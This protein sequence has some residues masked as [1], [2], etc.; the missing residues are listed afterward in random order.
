M[1][2]YSIAREFCDKSER[3]LGESNVASDAQAQRNT[4]VAMDDA[5]KVQQREPKAP[6]KYLVPDYEEHPQPSEISPIYEDIDKFYSSKQ[7]TEQSGWKRGK[8]D[9]GK[10]AEKMDRHS[11]DHKKKLKLRQTSDDSRTMLINSKHNKSQDEQKRIFDG[12]CSKVSE[13]DQNN[14]EEDIYETMI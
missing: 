11:K 9:K 3:A 7:T 6:G 14:D 8:N 10:Q 1:C 12:N 2:C 5:K 4:T 13:E